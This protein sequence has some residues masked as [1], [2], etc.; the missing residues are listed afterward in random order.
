MSDY[1]TIAVE[2]IGHVVRVTLDRPDVLNAF[3]AT[4]QRELRSVWTE[5]RS[6]DDARVVLL[7][8][9]GD[10]A[11]CVGID[12]EQP[13]TAAEADG[14]S[15][16]R[17]FGTSNGFMYDDPGNDLGPKACGL[18][19]PVVA[20]VNGM[21]C[22]GAFYLLSE[23]D[24]I[25]ASE[26]ATFFDPHVTYGM[27]AVYEPIKMLQRMSLGDVLRMSLL[28]AH[29][30]ISAATAL[31][32]GLVSEVVAPDELAGASMWVAESIAS[33]PPLAVQA[34]L[35]AIW[36]GNDLARE[37]ALSLAPSILAAGTSAA[38]IRQGQEVFSSGQR[39]RA[40]LR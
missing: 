7:D 33:Q 35:R 8:A 28:G 37:Q 5:L 18:W 3:N 26:T 17:V 12:R 27:A 14:D 13:M 24:V 38:T 1:E 10:R 4:M 40:R 36:A 30:R 15:A 34:T 25:V 39:I 22:G 2:R 23:V 31:R 20:A 19:K 9:R 6:D 11:F 29:E 16:H 32:I 21:A